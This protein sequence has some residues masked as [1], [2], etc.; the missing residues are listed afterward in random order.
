MIKMRG[1]RVLIKA[2]PIEKKSKG[3]IVIVQDEKLERTGVQR[4]IVV[5][6][7]PDCWKAYRQ[8]D[9]DTRDEVNGI[10]WAAVGD[11]VL[12]SRHA[13][14]FVEDPMDGNALYLV[15]NDEDILGIIR[16]GVNNIPS[17]PIKDK[18]FPDSEDE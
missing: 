17:N 15:M 3:G 14:R 6:V 2:D 8:I 18:L 7:G 9:P 12:F 5:D 4:G 11:Y 13:G 16:D 1:H 10:P